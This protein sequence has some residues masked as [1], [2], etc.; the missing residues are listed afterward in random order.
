MH[1]RYSADED[2][3][4]APEQF[5]RYFSAWRRRDN[6][7]FDCNDLAEA[8]KALDGKKRDNAYFDDESIAAASMSIGTTTRC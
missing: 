3:L 4:G 8:M 1:C 6:A 2:T 5:C 7:Y